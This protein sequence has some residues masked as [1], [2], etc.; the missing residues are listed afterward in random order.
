MVDS[1]RNFRIEAVADQDSSRRG[2]R[3]SRRSG[4]GAARARDGRR[5]GGGS[6]RGR[7]RPALRVLWLENTGYWMAGIFL[8]YL[9]SCVT[10]LFNVPYSVGNK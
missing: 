2:R 3:R 6:S 10:C 1:E 5:S 7:V 9:K 4:A 8:N